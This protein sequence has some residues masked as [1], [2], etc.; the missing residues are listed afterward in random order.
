MLSLHS[1]RTKSII[2]LAIVV[3]FTLSACGGTSTASKG[4]I[5]VGGK[6]DTEAQLL[7][8]MYTL[9]LRKAGFDVTEKA[10]LGDNTII[11]QAITHHQ[12]DLYPE[13]T[14]TALNKLGLASAN[15]PHKDYL[16]VKDAFNKQYQITW[17]DPAPLND[18]YALCT[19]KDEARALG[20]TKISQLVSKASSLVLTSPSDGISAIDTLQSAYGL[21][22]KSFKEVSTVQYALG[23]EAV[24]SNQSQITVCYTTDATVTTNNFIFLNDDKHGFP[25]YN[26]AP[27]VRNDTLQKYPDIETALN[28]LA[29]KLTTDV[30][31]KL[32]GQVADKKKAGESGSQAITDAATKFLQDQGLL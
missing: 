19:T 13:F 1:L 28:P 4:S 8:K 6:L 11:F 30:S 22:T 16:N 2:L 7:T 21:T 17:L 5:T 25:E 9:L 14:A 27:I 31:V 10:A 20:V 29:P 3:I 26:P 12:I 18:G 24:K 32:Q 15:D 23:F